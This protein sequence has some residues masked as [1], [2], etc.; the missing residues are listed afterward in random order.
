MTHHP[1]PGTVL[2]VVPDLFF[3][4]RI[5]ETAKTL[6]VPLVTC[7]PAALHERAAA[8]KPARV[9]VD[10]HAPGAIDAVRA[11]RRDPETHGL[12]VIG[13]FSHVDIET[14]D[15]AEAAGVNESLPRSAFTVRLAK[16][17]QGQG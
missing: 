10:L 14:R 3:E 4:A 1:T 9:I 15:A 7:A 13:F 11:L 17:L 16:I 2:A 5:V 8:L 6:G 12:R